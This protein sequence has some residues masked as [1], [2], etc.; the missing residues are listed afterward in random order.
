MNGM[1]RNGP[2]LGGRVTERPSDIFRATCPCRRTTRR[3]S[4]RSPRSIGDD[5]VLFGSDY[6]APRRAGR[7]GAVRRPRRGARRAGRRQDHARQPA[8]ALLGARRCSGI[9]PQRKMRRAEVDGPARPGRR[10]ASRGRGGR[11]T[12]PRGSPGS[13]GRRGGAAPPRSRRRRSGSSTCTCVGPACPGAAARDRRA[14][15]A[16]AGHRPSRR[17]DRC[18]RA[19][20]ARAPRSCIAR[21]VSIEFTTA[22]AHGSSSAPGDRREPPHRPAPTCRRRRSAP[23]SSTSPVAASGYAV[24][25]PIGSASDR[26][27]DVDRARRCARSRGRG[28]R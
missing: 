26:G 6:P 28:T 17:R 15:A 4:S 14:R 19:A 18:R 25:Q 23:A 22:P 9:E 3:T 12:R 10:A 24:G 20:A 27:I 16:R 21:T 2:W 11:S 5:R 13:R 1:G 8:R 7:A